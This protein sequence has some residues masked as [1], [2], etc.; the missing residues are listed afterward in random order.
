MLL[1]TNDQLGASK[2]TALPDF[3]C[4]TG[5]DTCKHILGK[6][7]KTAF[8]VFMTSITE[9][10]TAIAHLGSGDIPSA[11]V[12]SGCEEFLCRHFSNKKE[13]TTVAGGNFS[14][15]NMQNKASKTFPPT[16]ATWY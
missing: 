7:K 14:K 16:S 8:S 3:L 6:G 11:S 2:A 13:V 5:Y 9:V 12:V 10:I 1:Q 15:T 4:L